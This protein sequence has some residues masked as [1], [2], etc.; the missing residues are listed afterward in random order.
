VIG[1]LRIGGHDR[2]RRILSSYIDGQVTSAESAR[3]ERH[4]AGCRECMAEL[5][6]LRATVG[7]LRAL[8]ELAIPRS[9]ALDSVPAPVLTPWRFGWATGMAATAAAVL[10]IALIAGDLTGLLRQTGQVMRVQDGREAEAPVVAAAAAAAPLEVAAAPVARAAPASESTEAA[11]A[12]RAAEVEVA[13]ELERDAAPAAAAMAA[14]AP[15]APDGEVVKEVSTEDATSLEKD[16]APAIAAMAAPAPEESVEIETEVIKEGSTE[17]VSD[18][19]KDAAPAIAA[20]AAPAADPLA[21][22]LT[23]GEGAVARKVERGVAVEETVD[24]APVADAPAAA[25]MPSRELAPE[26]TPQ[27]QATSL[28]PIAAPQAPRSDA[29]AAELEDGGASLPLLEL[30]LASGALLAL[31][32]LVFVSLAVRRRRAL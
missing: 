30:E 31:L 16:A 2:L 9:F 14:P 18:L 3:V 7:L 22:A 10:L 12:P 23:P 19:E 15:K 26:A 17:D 6:N 11:A 8:P 25:A 21:T 5:E 32:V 1:F 4:L 20:M 28:A 29:G 27:L 13:V 24:E